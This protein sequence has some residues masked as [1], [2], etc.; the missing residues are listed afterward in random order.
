[1]KGTVYEQFGLTLSLSLAEMCNS[2][3]QSVIQKR[4]YGATCCLFCRRVSCRKKRSVASWSWGFCL[5]KPEVL[6]SSQG[7]IINNAKSHCFRNETRA[8]IAEKEVLVKCSWSTPFVFYDNKEQHD[9]A[10]SKVLGFLRLCQVSGHTYVLPVRSFFSWGCPVSYVCGRILLCF[11]PA[12]ADELL[13]AV[14]T[15]STHRHFCFYLA[16]QVLAGSPG[17]EE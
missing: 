8:S 4:P 9:G 2:R 13:R 10:N 17:L 11:C 3:W 15:F 14:P 12:D 6:F 5:V 1:M 16:K 7:A